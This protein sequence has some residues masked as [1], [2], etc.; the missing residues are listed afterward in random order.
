MLIQ[1]SCF[2]EDLLSLAYS[3]STRNILY[4]GGFSSHLNG[5]PVVPVL[6][7]LFTLS[8]QLYCGNPHVRLTIN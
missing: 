3:Q 4:E 6:V 5:E 8:F 1:L 7:M 2:T